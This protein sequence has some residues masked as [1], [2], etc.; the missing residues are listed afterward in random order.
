[1]LLAAASRTWLKDAICAIRE[2]AHEQ[3][4]HELARRASRLSTRG[5]EQRIGIRFVSGKTTGFEPLRGYEEGWD[6]NQGELAHTPTKAAATNR[7]P[8]QIRGSRKWPCRTERTRRSQ[9][10]TATTMPSCQG[11]PISCMECVRPFVK[12]CM[13]YQYVRSS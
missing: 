12:H 3:P 10:C 11:A 2:K 13:S 7:K 6:A 4:E 8:R 5:L 9:T 1:V